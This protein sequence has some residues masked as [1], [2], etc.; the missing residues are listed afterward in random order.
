MRPRWSS[1]NRRKSSMQRNTRVCSVSKRWHAQ[2]S[3][4][5]AYPNSSLHV[6]IALPCSLVRNWISDCGHFFWSTSPT[7]SSNNVSMIRITIISLAMFLTGIRPRF[8][9]CWLTIRNWPTRTISMFS[10]HRS[11]SF[12]V[13][14]RGRKRYVKP[15]KNVHVT[16]RQRS[17][18]SS[19]ELVSF[20]MTGPSQKPRPA[21]N[22]SHVRSF[23]SPHRRQPGRIRS[24]RSKVLWSRWWLTNRSVWHR[25]FGIIS[26]EKRTDNCHSLSSSTRCSTS[27]SNTLRTPSSP[28]I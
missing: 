16:G 8:D 12:Y 28:V 14:T 2:H 19:I 3:K 9:R 22:V 5:H 18:H 4:W 7:I 23:F 20:D 24:Q 26:V 21:R 25:S 10:R 15:T 27:S 11:I 17:R 13:C 6:I 1:T